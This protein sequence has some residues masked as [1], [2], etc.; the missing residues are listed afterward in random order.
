MLDEIG[1]KSAEELFADIPEKMRYRKG[2]NLP[3]PRSEYEVR[4]H[5]E[6][7]LSRNK[8]CNELISFLGAGCWQHFVP[9]VCDEI[10]SRSEFLTAYAGDPYTDLGRY[11]SFFEF[12]SMIGELVDMDVVSFPWYDWATVAGDAVR[13][14]LMVTNRHELLVPRTISPERLSVLRTY[15]DGQADIRLVECSAETGQLSVEDLKRKISQKTAAVYIENPA[16]LG[17]IETGGE[18]ISKIVHGNESLFMVGVEPLSLGI[19]T[20]PGEYGAD[21]VCGEGQPLGMHMYYGGALLG[22]LACRDDE[23]LVS[24]VPHRLV[25]ITKTEREGEWGFAYVL[26][27]RT[28]FAARDK[29]RSFTG[30]G[31][32]LWAI[33]AAV[34]MSLV[35][36]QGMRE[37]AE[38][39]MEKSHYA[40]KRLSEI[41]GLKVPVFNA[42][43]FEEFTVNFDA[44]GKSVQE[45]NRLLMKSGII[46][47]KDVTQ[48]FPE[49]GQTS[50]FCVTEIHS[51]AEIDKLATALQEAVQ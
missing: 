48:E 41:R 28:M 23:R 27:K 34:Y 47:G 31:T 3:H 29:A 24:A 14:A 9:A 6:S 25:T 49:L 11:Q 15:C 50:L 44:A 32:A 37:L 2:L 5:V 43:H 10:N 12:Q 20:P 39:I 30:T 22:F 38:A 1:V 36:P 16:Y 45:I 35:G 46:G 17:F 42:P 21:I 51:K 8:T 33:T 19:L 26:P 13:M 4:R 18:E 40:M 7:L